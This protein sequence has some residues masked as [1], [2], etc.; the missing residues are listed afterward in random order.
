MFRGISRWAVAD[1]GFCGGFERKGWSFFFL[2]FWIKS[3]VGV[4][5]WSVDKIGA[6]LIQSLVVYG[7]FA[8]LAVFSG[9]LG[10][11]EGPKL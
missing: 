7:M 4:A 10:D 8:G 6:L 11:K 2:L 5:S 3:L 1:L 9:G